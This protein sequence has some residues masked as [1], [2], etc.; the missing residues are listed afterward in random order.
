MAILLVRFKNLDKN[1]FLEI[2]DRH[3][4]YSYGLYQ[5]AWSGICD[6]HI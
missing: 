5:F 2:A 4:K 3:I 6:G 1:L